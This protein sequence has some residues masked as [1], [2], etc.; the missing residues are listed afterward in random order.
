MEKINKLQVQALSEINSASDLKQL[1]QIRVNYLGK[2][3]RL[4]EQ[5]KLVGELPIEER[6]KAGQIINDVKIEIHYAKNKYFVDENQIIN[7]IKS[8]IHG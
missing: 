5:L 2:K 8:I 1:D 7:N 3:G 6:P 4:T